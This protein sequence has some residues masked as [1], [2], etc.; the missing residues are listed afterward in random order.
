MSAIRTEF[1][2]KVKDQRYQMCEGFCERCGAAL[3]AGHIEFHHEIEAELGGKN[4][5][6]NCRCLCRACHGL[7]TSK[8]AP[9]LAKVR[10]ARR[11]H[12]GIRKPSKWGIPGMKK[13]VSGRVVKR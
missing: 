10:R 7:I 2:A 11:K 12:L 4:E 5:V 13:T 8:R 1:S 3:R 6:G 9:V